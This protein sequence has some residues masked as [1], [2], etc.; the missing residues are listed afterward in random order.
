[1]NEIEKLKSENERYKKALKTILYEY[2]TTT[3]AHAISNAALN[4][5]PATLEALQQAAQL[6]TGSVEFLGDG[7]V[8]WR[9]CRGDYSSF[10]TTED[11]IEY[12]NNRT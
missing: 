5:P 9:G 1:M 12:L 6:R 7:S 4:F 11:L 3:T 10:A 2:E 8:V